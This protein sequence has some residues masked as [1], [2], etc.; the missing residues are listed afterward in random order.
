MTTGTKQLLYHDNREDRTE[1]HRLLCRLA[2]A[3][4]LQ[5][6]RW[7][8][9]NATL[10]NS[11]VRPRVSRKTVELA[12]L[13]RHDDSADRR[14]SLECFFDLMFLANSYSFDLDQALARLVEMVRRRPTC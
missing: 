8:C 5:F 6:L 2:P 11:A 9:Q 7:A 14:L 13:A 10:P 3:D 4:R 12:G 1:I